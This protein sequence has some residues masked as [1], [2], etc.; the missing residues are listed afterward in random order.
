MNYNP[1]NILKGKH[2]G[3]NRKPGDIW[4]TEDEGDSVLKYLNSAAS[5]A[6]GASASA[7]RKDYV[8]AGLGGA[9]SGASLG[10]MVG[11]MFAA[12]GAAAGS[13]VPGIGT[14]IGAGIGLGAGLLGTA[15]T[16]EENENPLDAEYKTLTNQLLKED[17]AAKKRKTDWQMK[18]RNRL[19]FGA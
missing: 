14:L 4:F 19:A 7:Q 2:A 1:S 13:V 5:S 10:T 12:G 9:A 11:G 3:S 6:Q 16:P 18:F 17:L 8:G 15:L